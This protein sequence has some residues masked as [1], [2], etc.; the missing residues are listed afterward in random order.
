MTKYNKLL[1]RNSKKKKKY[2]GGSFIQQ[3]NK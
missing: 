1:K 2:K 3:S